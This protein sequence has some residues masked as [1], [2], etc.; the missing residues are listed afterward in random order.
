MLLLKVLPAFFLG[1]LCVY[2]VTD[3]LPCKVDSRINR[4]LTEVLPS[5]RLTDLLTDDF[6]LPCTQVVVAVNLTECVVRS[7]GRGTLHCNLAKVVPAGTHQI[8]G[9]S[10]RRFLGC[11]WQVFE[12]RH[13]L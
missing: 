12:P 4:G 8:H 10:Y 11:A 1:F 9:R 7:S 13:V 6:F 2:R 3:R 5:Q